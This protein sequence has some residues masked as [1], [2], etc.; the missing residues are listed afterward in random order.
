MHIMCLLELLTTQESSGP[1]LQS[2]KHQA[3]RLERGSV[4]VTKG[5]AVIKILFVHLG[6]KW[7]GKLPF[8]FLFECTGM[9]AQYSFLLEG[10]IPPYVNNLL[11]TYMLFVHFTI[12]CM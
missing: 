12:Q 9:L 6:G 10:N 1:V 8:L 11:V 3:E 2:S 4:E 7:S 5:S